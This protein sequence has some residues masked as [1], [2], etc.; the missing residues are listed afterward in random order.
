MWSSNPE[1]PAWGDPLEWGSVGRSMLS[2]REG[3]TSILSAG[4]ENY[5][6]GP[7]SAFPVQQLPVRRGLEEILNIIKSVWLFPQLS[8]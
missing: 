7:L 2:V 3:M 8:V 4:A 6:G 5:H 1:N